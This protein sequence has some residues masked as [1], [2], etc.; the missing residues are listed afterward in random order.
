MMKTFLVI[1]PLASLSP[2]L[3]IKKNILFNKFFWLGLFI[4]FIPFLYWAL[5]INH[6]LDKNIIFSD[7]TTLREQFRCN[8]P[9]CI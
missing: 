3:F 2:Y 6:Y 8:F 9:V 4:G 1:V 5:S 7:L